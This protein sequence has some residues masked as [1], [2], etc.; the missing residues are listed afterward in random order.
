MAPPLRILCFGASLV[1]GHTA[2]GTRFTPYS[3]RL[4]EILKEINA[5]VEVETDGK[6]GDL[7]TSGFEERMAARCESTF[8]AF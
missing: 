6:S 4:R 2:R 1:E 3:A 8:S 7:L 5:D